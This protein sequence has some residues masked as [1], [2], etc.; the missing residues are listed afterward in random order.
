MAKKVYINVYDKSEIVD[1]AGVLQ[2]KFD[3]EIFSTG[4]TLEHLRQN[5]IMAIDIADLEIDERFGQKDFLEN[6]VRQN[7]DMVIVNFC[8]ASKT[9]A[10]T[11]DVSSFADAINLFDYSILRAAAKCY[12]STI[13]VTSMDDFYTSINVNID[14][15]QKLALKAFQYLA[16]YDN[17][18]AEKIG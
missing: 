2:E 17:D 15:R 14:E 5:G 4:G 6:F 1:Y 9:A 8:P 7:F 12:D 3:Y 16:D 13:C 10:E 11:D 18:I